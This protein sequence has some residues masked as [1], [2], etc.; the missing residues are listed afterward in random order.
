MLLVLGNLFF[1]DGVGRSRCTTQGKT[2]RRANIC[3]FIL[4]QG[5]RDDSANGFVAGNSG[6][7]G[8]VHC[9]RRGAGDAKGDADDILC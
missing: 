8:N 4:G 1:T 6:A 7:C 5:L 2:Y 3:A 9:G